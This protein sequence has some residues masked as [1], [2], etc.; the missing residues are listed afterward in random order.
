MVP[1][2]APFPDKIGINSRTIEQRVLK[3]LPVYK[4]LYGGK[5]SNNGVD[6]L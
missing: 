3:G 6:F 5:L 4:C 1:I 2:A